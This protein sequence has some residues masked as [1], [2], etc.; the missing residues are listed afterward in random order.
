[1]NFC[2]V[3]SKTTTKSNATT[4][5]YKRDEKLIIKMDCNECKK[6]TKQNHQLTILRKIIDQMNYN[7]HHHHHHRRHRRSRLRRRPRKSRNVTLIEKQ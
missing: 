1:M 4:N 2:I 3:L 5:G 6:E 7:H